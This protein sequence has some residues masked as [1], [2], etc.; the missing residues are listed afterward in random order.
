VGKARERLAELGPASAPAAPLA[1]ADGAAQGPAAPPAPG[2]ST[3]P[4]AAA[5]PRSAARPRTSDPAPSPAARHSPAPARV[6]SRGAHS[7]P[8]AAGLEPAVPAAALDARIS[9][10]PAPARPLWKRWPVWA[11]VAVGVAAAT[12]GIILLGSRDD[13]GC[14]GVCV[15]LR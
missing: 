12:T 4:G 11:G 14:D 7:P 8:R 9:A 5:P 13:G 3:S 1:P 10:E 15:D 2:A 6:T